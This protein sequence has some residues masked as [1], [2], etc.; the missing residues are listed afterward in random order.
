MI[1]HYEHTYNALWVVM[2]RMGLGLELTLTLLI[3][4]IILHY[5]HIVTHFKY[6]HN[7]V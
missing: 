6:V 7:T 3:T 1:M 5:R 4:M 2:V